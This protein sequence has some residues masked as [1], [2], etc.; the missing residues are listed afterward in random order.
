[1]TVSEDGPRP[2]RSGCPRGLAAL[3]IVAAALVQ[4]RI[5]AAGPSARPRH[6]VERDQVAVRL[7]RLL[8]PAW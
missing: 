7:Q 6:Q 8:I 4:R 5:S 2:A 3:A 1:M